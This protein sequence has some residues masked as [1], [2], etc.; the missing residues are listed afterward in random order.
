MVRNRQNKML[1]IE[2][3]NENDSKELADYLIKIIVEQMILDTKKKY[4]L[5]KNCDGK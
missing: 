1:Q 4:N 2:F 3:H 5:H